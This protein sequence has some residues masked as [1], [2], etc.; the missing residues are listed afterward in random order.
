[1]DNIWRGDSSEYRNIALS[2][3]NSIQHEPPVNSMQEVTTN[4][5]LGDHEGIARGE[6]DLLQEERFGGTKR[7]RPRIWEKAYEQS[8]TE[9]GS[10]GEMEQ[11]QATCPSG[12]IRRDSFGYLYKVPEQFQEDTCG[13]WRDGT[14]DSQLDE[15]TERMALGEYWDGE[16]SESTFGEPGDVCEEPE[17]V[18]VWLQIAIDR[19]NRGIHAGIAL[20]ELYETVGGSLSFQSGIQGGFYD[21]KSREDCSDLELLD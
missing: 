14:E 12:K 7:I 1:M 4:S 9:T 8:G 17:Q 10:S 5:T 13:G 3:S 21:D 18:V 15:A 19:I 20:R 11:H 16:E 2:R 6:R